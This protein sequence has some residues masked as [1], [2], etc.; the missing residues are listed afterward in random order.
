[1]TDTGH[2]LRKMLVTK[3][4]FRELGHRMKHF[5]NGDAGLA[6]RNLADD[7]LS[8]EA[9]E[10]WSEQW[11]RLYPAL[12]TVNARNALIIMAGNIPFVGLH[13]LVCV[14]AAGH[15]AIVKPSSKDFENMTWVVEQ[16][17][18]IEPDLPVVLADNSFSTIVPDAVVAM[19]SDETV[20]A[21]RKQFSGMTVGKRD[22]PMLLRGNRSSFAILSGR[23]EP[24][25]LEGLADDVLSYSGLGCRN[26]S[27]VFVP[28]GYDFSKLQQSMDQR[29]NDLSLKYCNNY[30]SMRALLKMSDIPHI[31]CGACML[32][33]NQ[34]FSS[35][36]SV[37]NYAYYDTLDEVKDWVAKH[38]FEI[39]CVAASSSLSALGSGALHPRIVALGATQRPGLTDYPDGRDTMQFL[40]GII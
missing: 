8:R 3:E 32:V 30:R 13:D 36:P 12:P 10:S 39:Q 5:G 4:V 29:K 37:L 19:G 7:M 25:E 35:E 17:I 21:I 40:A 15:R 16:L 23:E 14:L 24:D 31:D 1:M 38:D 9:L 11:R 27:L 6:A 18:D 28:R 26:V 2:T 34:E 22:V 20:T 33:E